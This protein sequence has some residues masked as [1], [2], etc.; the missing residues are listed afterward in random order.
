MIRRAP[1]LP[2]PMICANELV[3]SGPDDATVGF[4]RERFRGMLAFLF[5]T[6]AYWPSLELFGWQDIGE[7]LL[8]MTREGRWQEMPSLLSD[9][10]VDEFLVSGRFE[11]LPEVLA[12]RF[13]GLVQR[14]TL[15]VPPQPENDRANAAAIEAI[16][17]R[18]S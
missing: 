17:R 1:G 15:T 2:P 11:V 7:R 18:L 8:Q 6:P 4:E 13:Q 5:S 10:V 9:A 12:S 14:I 3:A 16:R